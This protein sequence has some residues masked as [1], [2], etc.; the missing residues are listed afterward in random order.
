MKKA[1][2]ISLVCVVLSGC[3]TLRFAPTEAQKQNAWLHNRTAIATRQLAENEGSSQRLQD[4][5]T[6]SEYQSRDFCSYYGLPKSFPQAQTPQQI[7]SESNLQITEQA[8]NDASQRPDEW[9]VAD[10]LLEMG[11]AIAAIFGGVYGTKVS[12][13][14]AQAKQKSNALREII[15]GNELFKQQN[16]ESATAFKTAQSSQSP[17]TRQLVAQLK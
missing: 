13:F 4:L 10:G 8:L 9:D 5:A 1:I 12:G 7:L 17:E 2:I 15:E 6:L 14:L 11:I 16:P 3:G